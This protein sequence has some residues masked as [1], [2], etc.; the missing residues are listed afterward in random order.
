MAFRDQQRSS[1]RWSEWLRGVREGHSF[2]E[3]SELMS[4]HP[5]DNRTTLRLDQ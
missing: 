3:H 1:V 5:L 2:Q 4:E